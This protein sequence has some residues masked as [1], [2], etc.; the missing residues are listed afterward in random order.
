MPAY[1]IVVLIGLVVLGALIAW[2]GDV[3]GYRLGKQRASIFGLRPRTTA[4]L[5]GAIAGALLP[6]IGLVVAMALSPMARTALL[7]LDQLTQEQQTLKQ[8]IDRQEASARKAR[9]QAA[10]FRAEA[11]KAQ[12]DSR[13]L[14]GLVDKLKGESSRLKQDVS[15]LTKTRNDLQAK[16]SRIEKQYRKAREQLAAAESELVAAQQELAAAQS[17]LADAQQELESAESEVAELE[18][19]NKELQAEATKLK[20]DIDGLRQQIPTLQQ[21]VAE[22]RDEVASTN[23]QLSGTKQELEEVRRAR[24]VRLEQLGLLEREYERYRKRQ[25]GIAESPVIYDAG[26]VL[27][28]AIVSTEQTEEQ[29]AN[30]LFEMLPFA[31]LAAARKGA[32]RGENGR[33]TLLV[34]P[35]PPEITDREPTEY[36]IVE[37]WAREMK[38]LSAIDKFVVSVVAF[39]RLTVAEQDQLHVA[40]WP[41]PNVRVFV[42][43]EVIAETVVEADSKPV[44]IFKNIMVLLRYKVRQRAQ[45]EG[46]LAN[47]ETG[48][49]GAIDAGELFKLIEEI[50]EYDCDV[51]VQVMPIED[52]Y[53]AD[54]LR[55]KFVIHRESPT[56]SD[57]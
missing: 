19:S 17:K 56:K 11:E 23:E 21:Q 3:I 26:D 51:K 50:E 42:Q 33:A 2:A 39:R 8:T 13:L 30:T 43:D 57:E 31:S 47:P 29:L 6:L 22:L 40:M 49:Y 15:S 46:L 14:R 41:R 44:D 16:V 34:A 35:W 9:A 32:V 25:A 37:Y 24:D 53:T 10:R 38:K 4:R 7:E 52:I 48:Q 20:A 18:T 45:Q 36:D 5:V 55:I 54:Q 1:T 12:D 28:R 27:L